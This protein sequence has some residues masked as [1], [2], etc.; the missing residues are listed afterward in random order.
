VKENSRPQK[1]PANKNSTDS[2][3]NL[4]LNIIIL[5]LA[6]VIIFMS[7]SLI[8]KIKNSNSGYSENGK[9]ASQTIQV[10][11]LNGC[12]VAGVAEQLTSFLR[13]HKFDVV[14][15]GN[16]ISYDVEKSIVIDRT[17]NE[18]NAFKVA[19]SLGISRENVIQQINSNY[20]LDVSIIIGKDYNNLKPF[21]Q[22]D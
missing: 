10:E 22:K 16:Y 6:A 17:G 11:V 9:S 15:M 21:Q 5:L 7:Y 19:D 2:S 12:G 8:V 14:Q 18:A 4:F 20:F 3:N 1:R 13:D